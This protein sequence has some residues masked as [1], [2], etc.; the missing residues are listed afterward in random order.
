LIKRTGLKAVSAMFVQGNLRRWKEFWTTIIGKNFSWFL[1]DLKSRGCGNPVCGECSL[2]K[3]NG[4]RV[5]S[6]CIYKAAHR[7]AE[8]RREDQLDSKGA[9]MKIYKKQLKKER[10]DLDELLQKK[11]ELDKMVKKEANKI[12]QYF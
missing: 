12:D 9:S 11:H 5:C 4:H 3:V 7:R 6:V 10:G 1:V 2:S 8:E